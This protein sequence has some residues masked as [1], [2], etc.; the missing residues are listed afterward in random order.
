MPEV[1]YLKV[2]DSFDCR[3]GFHRPGVPVQVR[4]C[5]G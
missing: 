2:F 4:E 5:L 3:F 1:Y